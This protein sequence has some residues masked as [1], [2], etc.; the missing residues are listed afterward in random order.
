MI[1]STPNRLRKLAFYGVSLE[2]SMY[3]LISAAG[4]LSLG[5]NFMV[6]LIALRPG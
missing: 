2:T 6:D 3:M 5:D 1:N 4:Y